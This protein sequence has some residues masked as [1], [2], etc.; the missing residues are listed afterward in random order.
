MQATTIST[1]QERR[2][3]A[4]TEGVALVIPKTGISVGEAQRLLRGWLGHETHVAGALR[5]MAKGELILSLR[6]DG[7]AVPVAAPAQEMRGSTEAWLDSGA[8]AVMRETDG[9]RYATWLATVA[10]R[11]D[12]ALAI[13]RR[14]AMFGPSA[15]RA[16]SWSGIAA[17]LRDQG[18]FAEALAA[19]AEALRLDPHRFNAWNLLASTQ[20]LLGHDEMA[21]PPVSIYV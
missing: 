18:H 20:Q 10:G 3:A 2:S 5:P 17:S 21:H 9:Y 8:E 6:V 15:E 11:L 16:W 7:R 1:R 4:T 19:G 12:E 14:N 13:H